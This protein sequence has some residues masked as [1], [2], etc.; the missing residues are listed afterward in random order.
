MSE[1]GRD[2]LEDFQVLLTELES[3]SEDL[4]RK[5]MFVVASKMDASQ[6][7]EAVA[8]LQHA[9]KERNLPFFE[10]SS[11]TGAGLDKL[12]FAMAEAVLPVS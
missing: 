6:D 8:A 1:T 2:P 11:A 9:A 3:F 10:I 5:P 4:A 12:K 7:P